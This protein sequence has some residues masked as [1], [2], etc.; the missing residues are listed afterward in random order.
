M[1]IGTK[2]KQLRRERGI[3][4]EQL[5]EYL[6]ITPRAVSQWECERT[7][8]DISQLPLLANYFD[9]SADY[10]LGIDKARDEAETTAFL[11]EYN[12]LNNLG[13]SIDVFELTASIYK[14]YPNDFRVIEKYV[15]QLYQYPHYT[16]KPFGYVVH[17]EELYRLCQRIMDECTIDQLRYSAIG[18]LSTLYQNDKLYEKAVEYC[19]KFPNTY[20]ETRDEALESFY[21]ASDTQKYTEY[22]KRNITAFT[23]YLAI[24]LQKYAY[25]VCRSYDS[26][27]DE[28]LMVFEKA[29]SLI[30]L[31]YEDGDYGFCHYILGELY[32]SAANQ[33]AM[34]QDY[35][36]A[37][38]YLD[39]GLG[40]ARR[41]DELPEQVQ[42]TSL[43]VRGYIFKKSNVN[44]G[45]EENDVRREL[46][47]LATYGCYDG[48]RDE[49]WYRAL[50]AKYEPYA[51]DHK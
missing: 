13:R 6:G 19:E 47:Y 4:Q 37:A 45:F 18:I 8:P 15:W 30:K 28:K 51:K 11:D 49:D 24:K 23:E 14:R 10:L 50:I 27:S 32:I 5:A 1:S 26:G 31:I 43:A 3:T 21:L 39:I 12:R 41:Y 2:I 44:S 16:E 36:K 33:Y 46:G 22:V 29:I 48:V 34:K 35:T 17:K 40:H 9:V 38:E 25:N 42:H 20:Y 7:S